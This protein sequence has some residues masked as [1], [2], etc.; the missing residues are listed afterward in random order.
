M[1]AAV[2]RVE[3]RIDWTDPDYTAIFRARASRLV[4]LRNDPQLLANVRAWYKDHPADFISDWGV[5]VDPRM[6][7][8]DLPTIMPF[9]LFPRQRELI[10]WIIEVWRDS[11]G[12][13][14]EKSRDIGASWLAV[15]L[16]CTLCLF[17]RGITIGFGSRKEDL[18]D[19]S[20]DPS[21]LFY[22]GRQFMQYL[23]PEFRG[24]WNER[25][26]AQHLRLQFPWTDSAITGEA[27]D[28]I[29][30][31]G[32]TTMFF[33]DEA[34][35][36]ERPK[37]IDASLSA[38]TNCRVDMSSV[39]GMANSFAERRHGGRAKV[40]TFH[41]RDDPRKDDEWVANKRASFDD[42]VWAAEYEIDYTAS[43]E[44]I[45]IPAVW[46]TAAVDAHIKLGIEP[47]GAKTGALDV[48]DGGA[49]RNAFAVRH[50]I[51]VPHVESWKGSAD[52]DIFHSV[53]RSFLLCD[54]HGLE[55]FVYDADGLGA[56][57]RGDARKINEK[58]T[59]RDPR[60]SS[61]KRVEAYRGS[62]GVYKPESIV[63]GTERKAIDF[64]EN[65]KA[66]SWWT[67]KDRFKET[68]RA[69]VEGVKDYDPNNIISLS[70]ASP[71]LHQL[72][73]ELS[74]PTWKP[75]KTGKIMVEKAPEGTKSPNL[76]DGVVMVFAP[77]S[78]PMIIGRDVLDL[79]GAG[80][81]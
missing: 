24:E 49:D 23:P 76:A 40:F 27:G 65:Y 10:D 77:R 3:S 72:K 1:S 45:I 70:S 74:Q 19:R 8:R 80:K 73:T 59:E 66:Q 33:V 7:E 29:G 57:V 11:E 61:T 28:N 34:A 4:K 60:N 48:A 39:N 68:Y 31:G 42:V 81:R 12:G 41:Y 50:G 6:A 9:V 25:K 5:T 17:H 71:E 58:R 63:K 78:G 21:T 16:S 22:K 36:L 14:L 64:F 13:V 52:L 18:V 32:R 46:V 47:T 56:G 51:L 30:R 69:V 67:I 2:D 75:S 44:G 15:S 20:G 38:T 35:H 55:G 26:H 79:F 62:G 54:M 53:E 43:V 37:L